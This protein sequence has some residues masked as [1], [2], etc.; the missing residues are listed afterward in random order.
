MKVTSVR[1]PDDLVSR[2]DDLAV[3]ID[4]SRGW[5]IEQAIARY[6]DEEAW[7]V[8]AISEALSALRSGEETLSSHAEVMERLGELV[9]AKVQ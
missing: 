2:L 3:A 6:V 8:A 7:Q 1:L 9:H 5:L 4:R